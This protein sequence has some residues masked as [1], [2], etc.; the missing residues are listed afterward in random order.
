MATAPNTI[1]QIIKKADWYDP[2]EMSAYAFNLPKGMEVTN[3][4][5]I[6]IESTANTMHNHGSNE[7][8]TVWKTGAIRVFFPDNY[9]KDYEGMAMA[10]QKELLKSDFAVQQ[11]TGPNYTPDT[12]TIY[13]RVK[14]EKIE[15][16]EDMSYEV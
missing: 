4:I 3:K 7:P 9:E 6:L 8:Q 14:Y 1:L 13:I 12:E 5:L 11:W 10:I 16:I 2:K 15:F